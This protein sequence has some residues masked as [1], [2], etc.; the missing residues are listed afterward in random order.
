MIA[1]EDLDKF[2][3][4]YEKALENEEKTFLHE[5]QEVLVTY[6]KYLIEHLKNVTH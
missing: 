1:K 2:K 6:A 3:K 5:G 4:A